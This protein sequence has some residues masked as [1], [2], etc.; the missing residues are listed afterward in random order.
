M[1]RHY[2]DLGSD[3]DWSCRVANFFQP[4]RSTTQVWAVTRHQYGISTFV[5]Q[6]TSFGRETCGSV[7]KCQLFS[8]ASE[9][10]RN[11]LYSTC[12]FPSVYYLLKS[13]GRRS[14]HGF[15]FFQ[16]HDEC[17]NGQ[18]TCSQICGN[19]PGSYY[20]A[21]RQGYYLDGD[22][23]T[24]KGMLNIH[25]AL[26]TKTLPPFAPV[27]LFNSVKLRELQETSDA[28]EGKSKGFRLTSLC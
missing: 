9:P 23:R 5:S 15:S 24:C 6:Q 8:Q 4:I 16:D 28:A 26:I 14:F 3:S 18:H 17:K 12:T 7:A 21:C 2:P 19:T 1:G 25:A 20:C 11:N 22:F 10:N 27:I 13:L